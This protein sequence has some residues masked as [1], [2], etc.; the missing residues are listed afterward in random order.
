MRGW[1]LQ[2]SCS[3][4]LLPRATFVG[5]I[6]GGYGP[7]SLWS[8]SEVTSIVVVALA[9]TFTWVEL[10]EGIRLS[11]TALLA[12]AMGTQAATARRVA[13][14]DMTTVV[15]TSALV[16]LGAWVRKGEWA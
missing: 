12:V 6:R 14:T 5:L 8:S 10:T 15:V 7:A 13:V 3:A 1:R 16:G 11:S 4:Q 2:G 9:V